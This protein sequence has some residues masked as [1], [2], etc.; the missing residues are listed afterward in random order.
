MYDQEKEMADKSRKVKKVLTYIIAAITIAL[1]CWVVYVMTWY[2][3]EG[4]SNQQPIGGD[5]Q[6]EDGDKIDVS[7]IPTYDDL[8]VAMGRA[9]EDIYGGDVAYIEEQLSGN[10]SKFTL[11]NT[12][13]TLD[14]DYVG[15]DVDLMAL[16]VV[17]LT[18][19][20]YS[21]DGDHPEI[22]KQV[23]GYA[24]DTVRLLPDGTEI[25][26]AKIK[27]DYTNIRYF[28][29]EDNPALITVQGKVNGQAFI[30]DINLIP[31]YQHYANN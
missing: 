14:L 30:K 5:T 2:F 29:Q 31:Y 27:E 26:L 28:H 24:D 12:S 15:T 1:L 8:N 16:T 22:Y 3:L 4:G 9:V 7:L 20:P 19:N 18:R 17:S 13:I 10:K 6:V 23:L 11:P 21:I 25:D